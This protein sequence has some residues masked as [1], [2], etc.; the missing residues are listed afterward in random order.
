VGDQA[1]IALCA[2]QCIAATVQVE[3]GS[4]VGV[5]GRPYLLDGYAGD[6]DAL[7]AGALWRPGGRGE[8]FE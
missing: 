1:A 4:V 5:P 7:I 8:Q 2:A 3:K 6:G